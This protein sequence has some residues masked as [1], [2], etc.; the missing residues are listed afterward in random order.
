ME[1]FLLSV[2]V[3]R[4]LLSSYV[5]ICCILRVYVVPYMYLLYLMCI[6]C[7]MCVLLFLL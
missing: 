4:V 1:S 7:T 2:F 3:L 5:F 6:C